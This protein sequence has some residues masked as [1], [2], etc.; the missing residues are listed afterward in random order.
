MGGEWL[1]RRAV[2]QQR[3][4][5]AAFN[6][7]AAAMFLPTAN[8]L[9]NDLAV[10]TMRIDL[11]D[12]TPRRTFAEAAAP[13]ILAD[14]AALGERLSAIQTSQDQALAHAARIAGKRLRYLLEPIAGAVDGAGAL[15]K[16]LRDLQDTIGEMH[17]VHV[18]AADVILA[19]ETAGAEQARRVATALLESD[20]GDEE[21]RQQ[22]ARDPRLGLLAVAAQLRARGESAFTDLRQHWLGDQVRDLVIEA[23]RSRNP[24]AGYTHRRRANGRHT[25]RQPRADGSPGRADVCVARCRCTGCARRRPRQLGRGNAP[26]ARGFTPT[27]RL[28]HRSPDRGRHT[29]TDHTI[30]RQSERDRRRRRA[31]LTS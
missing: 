25:G 27:R 9:G 20:A 4:A 30:R 13:L 31:R 15:V 19:A 16:R 2:D 17:D 8:A 28:G 18:M 10:Y 7:A 21:A 22:H 11:R 5:G 24:Y 6:A 14:A 29:S 23:E 3:N 26:I 12:P 1:L